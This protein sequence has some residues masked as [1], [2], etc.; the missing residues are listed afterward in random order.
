MAPKSATVDPNDSKVKHLILELT[1]DFELL[2]P[3]SERTL[4]EVESSS[5]AGTLDRDIPHKLV[6]LKGIGRRQ[7]E[8]AGFQQLQWTLEKELVL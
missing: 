7:L 4:C 1:E 8:S 2:L 6:T 3:E 5:P